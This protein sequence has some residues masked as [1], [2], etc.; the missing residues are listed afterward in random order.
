MRVKRIY[1]SYW[2]L[3]RTLEILAAAGARGSS[4]ILLP[5][6]ALRREEAVLFSV[7]SSHESLNG[8]NARSATT[9]ERRVA[10]KNRGNASQRQVYHNCGFCLP[11]CRAKASHTSRSQTML[12]CTI[13][14]A[15]N[16]D[17]LWVCR[18]VYGRRYWSF[19]ACMLSVWKYDD[20]FN[21][22]LADVQLSGRKVFHRL[23]R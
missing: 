20:H 3:C 13:S 14:T 17:L 8:W 11:N 7:K 19:Q 1:E 10:S 15:S 2:R 4:G 16:V 12:M 18:P 21:L 23:R 9:A 6:A 22:Q 5:S